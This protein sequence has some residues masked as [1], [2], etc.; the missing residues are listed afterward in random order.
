MI[1]CDRLT[2]LGEISQHP[3]THVTQEKIEQNEHA[4]MQVAQEKI[5]QECAYKHIHAH[6]HIH[7]HVVLDVSRLCLG[8]GI[9]PHRLDPVLHT[10]VLKSCTS[11]LWHSFLTKLHSGIVPELC[12]QPITQ[13]HIDNHQDPQRDHHSY[14][15]NLRASWP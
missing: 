7:V 2:L 5:K 9:T 1:R 13:N 15:K 14:A 12:N 4:S 3:C 10:D 8:S 6:V 11:T